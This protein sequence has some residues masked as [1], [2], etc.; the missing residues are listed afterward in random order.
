VAVLVEGS[1]PSVFTHRLNADRLARIQLQFHQPYV[2]RSVPTRMIVV[3]DGNMFT[4]AVSREDGPLPMGMD[5]YT[6]QLFSNREFFENCLTYLTDTTGI[7]QARNKDFTLRLLD[8]QK[9]AR[10]KLTWQWLGF[11]I[12]IAF[13]LLFAAC[14]QFF[15]KRRYTETG[16]PSAR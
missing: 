9:V 2:S 7:I 12:P 8:K 5:P 3:G 10:Q 6:R 1:F 14:F 11:L 15:R 4:N 16:S 13:V